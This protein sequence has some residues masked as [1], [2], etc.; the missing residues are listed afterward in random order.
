MFMFRRGPY[1]PEPLFADVDAVKSAGIDGGSASRAP[2]VDHYRIDTSHVVDRPG[3]LHDTD[4]LGSRIANKQGFN[5]EATDKA[6]RTRKGSKLMRFARCWIA[7]PRETPKILPFRV[8]RALSVAS[9]LKPC[10]L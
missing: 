6:R 3:G 7:R 4:R 1:F 8:L 9:V 10:L 2:A 5:T